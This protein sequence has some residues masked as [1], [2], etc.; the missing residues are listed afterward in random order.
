MSKS[1]RLKWESD[2]G[3]TREFVISYFSRDVPNRFSGSCD[4]RWLA[5]GKNPR[6][7]I[8]SS[9]PLHP[10]S[11]ISDP[12]SPRVMSMFADEIWL[13]IGAHASSSSLAVLCRVSRKLNNILTPQLYI[14]PRLRSATWRSCLALLG[15]LSTH[16][17]MTKRL[18]MGRDIS[19]CHPMPRTIFEDILKAVEKCL[20]GQPGLVSL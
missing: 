20:Q 1:C 13:L 11:R 19:L 7:I 16:P 18:Y 4:H 10:A 14:A 8:T 17:N 9:G 5:E 15:S 6:I 3:P 2:N 12:S